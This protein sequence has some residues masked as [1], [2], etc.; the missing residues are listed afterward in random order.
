[1]PRILLQ[2]SGVV[3]HLA[4]V[5]V[6]HDGS[7]KLD[8]VRNGQGSVNWTWASVDGHA[9]PTNSVAV[10]ERKTKSITIHTTGRINYHFH[11][12]HTNYVPCL[13]DLEGPVPVVIY[14][15]P[16]LALLDEQVSP[17]SADFLEIVPDEVVGR[18][19]FRFDILPTVSPPE[20][21]ELCR[22]GVEGLFALSCIAIP[23]NGGVPLGDGVPASGFTTARPNGMLPFQ[24][25]A[26]EVAYLRFNQAKYASR[27]SGNSASTQPAEQSE[28]LPVE[29]MLALAPLLYPPN[30]EGVWTCITAV[31]MSITPKL[32]VTF[33]DARYEARVVNVNSAD[34]RLSTVRVRFKVFNK[35]T[36]AY[37][38]KI[39]GIV[40]IAL[41]TGF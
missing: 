2:Q 35:L 40:S 5:N 41:E 27:L 12:N 28:A 21:H 22:F 7:I 10:E 16:A 17:Q 33:S 25:I 15:V 29:A 39:V 11:P 30:Q 1:M 34:T 32:D 4:S 26:E 24:A 36:N 31:P 13:M 9:G 3:R 8:L 19:G 6:T 20:K 23:G 37:E 14:S 18:L 38:K